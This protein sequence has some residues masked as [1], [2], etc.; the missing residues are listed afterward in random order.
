MGEVVDTGESLIDLVQVEL[1]AG[2][3][4]DS[5]GPA[6]IGAVR[7]NRSFVVDRFG[8]PDDHVETDIERVAGVIG[9]LRI[10]IVEID[11]IGHEVDRRSGV[12][13]SG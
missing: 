7:V 8:D 9:V 12:S 3:E 11:Q 2:D 5:G 13:H 1:D 4:P 6:Q 10:E